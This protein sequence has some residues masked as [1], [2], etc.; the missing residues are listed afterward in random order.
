[1]DQLR[2][3]DLHGA[4]SQLP[5]DADRMSAAQQKCTPC[6]HSKW[7]RGNRSCRKEAWQKHSPKSGYL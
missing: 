3:C 6:N 7:T 4:V 1:A 2:R 5:D